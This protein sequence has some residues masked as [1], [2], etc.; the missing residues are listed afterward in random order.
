MN[1]SNY[2]VWVLIG[3]SGLLVLNACAS[4]RSNPFLSKSA[5]TIA[6]MHIG[7]AITGWPLTPKKQGLLVVAELASISVAT[8]SDILL[9]AARNG[10]LAKSKLLL[11]EIAGEIDPT[12]IDPEDKASY[13]LRR[14]A[15][16]SITHLQLASETDDASVNVQRTVTQTTI[17]AREIINKADELTAFLDAGLKTE[18]I[19]EMEVIAEEVAL[20]LKSIAGGPE[21]QN[22]YG[23]YDFRED[24]ESMVG[25]EE[26]AYETVES[27]YLFN[28]VKLPD[29]SWGF[30]SRRSRGAAGAGY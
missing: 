16:E 3:A 17:R 14:A 23:L 5:P 13:G 21:Q 7:H 24:I 26:P 11:A 29:G 10:D 22:N 28:L 20:A 19:D 6:H 15:A 18:S 30:A 8:K 4:G 25:R 9:S 12:L 27:F 2:L 1:R